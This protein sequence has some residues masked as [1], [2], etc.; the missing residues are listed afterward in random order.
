M[1]ELFQN[2]VNLNMILASALRAILLGCVVI[3]FQSLDQI[4]FRSE[5]DFQPAEDAFFPRAFRFA[6]SS[7]M[8]EKSI[9]ALSTI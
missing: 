7:F 2:L 4:D 3:D 9:L 6:I 8:R 5:Q 1:S